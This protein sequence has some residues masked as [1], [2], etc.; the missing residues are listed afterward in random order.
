[1]NRHFVVRL[2]LIAL[3][4]AAAVGCR[5]EE[6]PPPSFRVVLITSQPLSGRWERAA[7]QGL[8]RIAAVLDAEV[9]RR[10]SRNAAARRERLVRAGRAG[11]DLVFCVGPGFRRMV[12]TEAS[13][14]PGTR[15]VILPGRVQAANVAGIEFIPDGAGYLAGVVAGTLRSSDVVGVI[16]GSGQPWLE[17]LERGFVSGFQSVHRRSESVVVAAPEGPWE[18]ASRGV[19]VA[20]YA[21]DDAEQQVLAAAH[22]AGLLLVAT[23]TRLLADEPDVIAAAVVVDLPEAML[24]LA[25][26]VRDG[27][28]SGRIYGFDLGSG[29]LDV[30]LNQ[31]LPGVSLPALKEALDMARSRVTAGIVEIEQLGI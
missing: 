22:D 20:L 29:V 25:R 24:R 3:L 4:V 14:F 5:R 17:E 13:A 30:R 11:V 23:D 15:F 7:E 10:R 6:P 1:M 2:G 16:R 21:A 9:T 19:E 28:F 12:Y 26:E 18:L 31:T 27:S 8:G